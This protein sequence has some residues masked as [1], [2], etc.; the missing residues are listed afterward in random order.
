MARILFSFLGTARYS[1][2]RYA[3]DGATGGAG[4]FRFFPQALIAERRRLAG[5]KLPDRI[6]LCGTETS[7]WEALVSALEAP[8]APE[9]TGMPERRALSDIE[10]AA[11]AERYSPLLGIPTTAARISFARDADEQ[12]GFI[13]MVESHVD[14]GDSVEFDITHGLRHLP[15]VALTAAL[16]IRALKGVTVEAIWY[17]AYELK[18]AR[19]DPTPVIRLDGLLRTMD[20]ISAL[21]VFEATGD[22]TRFGP[23]IDGETHAG[24]SRRLADLSFRERVLQTSSIRQAAIATLDALD[25]ADEGVS[26]LVRPELQR[27]LSWATNDHRIDEGFD[28]ALRIAANGN[29]V[30][31]LTLAF[32][33]AV[34]KIA[35]AGGLSL[36]FRRDEFSRIIGDVAERRK[37][38]SS[39]AFAKAFLKLKKL[40]NAVVH[41]DEKEH[42]RDEILQ[43]SEAFQK[44]LK[45]LIQPLRLDVPKEFRDELAGM[46]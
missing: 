9:S 26:R 25:D 38:G 46:R 22:M 6:V 17:G 35:I 10:I 36:S 19:E 40:R 37:A 41:I 34:E 28:L 8:G 43:S 11:Y 4:P 44:G 45:I 5:R 24:T 20:W 12:L 29:E 2:T 14:R 18:T 13:A 15:L 39:A 30:R 42:R 1:P 33:T 3:F 27:R 21:T 32:E 23:L 16:A 31:A 7:G